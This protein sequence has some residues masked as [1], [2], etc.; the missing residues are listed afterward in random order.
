M[1]EGHAS[2][3]LVFNRAALEC[4]QDPAGVLAD[5]GTWTEVIGLVAD[6]EPD[7]IAA[8]ADHAGIHPDVISSRGGQ[9]GGLAAV[10]QQFS[11]DRHVFVGTRDEDRQIAQSLG[12]EFVPVTEAADAADWMLADDG[13]TG[14]TEE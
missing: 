7:R 4:L 8:F 5:A 14:P 13:C 12:W 9:T 11:T 10:R 6:E 1:D 2:L 3:T